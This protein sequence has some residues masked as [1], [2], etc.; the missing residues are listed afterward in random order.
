MKGR[1]S[2]KGVDIFRVSEIRKTIRMECLMLVIYRPE[3]KSQRNKISPNT[4]ELEL[5]F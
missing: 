5:E 2:Q 1:N 4:V 3:I